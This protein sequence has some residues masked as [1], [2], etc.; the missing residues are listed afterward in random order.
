MHI[1]HI[2]SELAPIAKVGGLGDVIH[3]LSK[4]LQSAGHTVEILLPKYDCLHYEGLKD[5]KVAFREL[6]VLEGTH[7]YN[8]TIWSA[9]IDGLNV[10]LIEPHHPQYYFTRGMIYGCHDDIDRFIY[11][12][13]VAMEYL[14]KAG[15]APDVIHV[16]DWPTALA[17]V[18]FKDVY[19]PLGYQGKGTVLT[20]HNMEHQ[21]KCQPF[22]LSKIGLP[23]ESY[24]APDKMQD[25]HF[26]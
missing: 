20:L 7:R 26:P 4:E 13:K 12:S 6:W 19:Q 16:H 3:G 11:F 10:I 14:F 22:N 9:R 15:K 23:G 18:L 17:A 5:L 25:P 2:A 8:N 24:L 1:V 21:G